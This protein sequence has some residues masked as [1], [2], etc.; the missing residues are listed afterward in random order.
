[1]FLNGVTS[2]KS[3]DILNRIDC[4]YEFLFLKHFT[5][6]AVFTKDNRLFARSMRKMKKRKRLIKRP[7]SIHWYANSS[8]PNIQYNNSDCFEIIWPVQNIT[9]TQHEALSA[10]NSNIHNAD[11][12]LEFSSSHLD[13]DKFSTPEKN[14]N[15]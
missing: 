5:I 12:H 2:L 4:T 3:Y 8:V 14:Y 7:G 9:T 6:R 15:T 10:L 11:S 1:M 13:V